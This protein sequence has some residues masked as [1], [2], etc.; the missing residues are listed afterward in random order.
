MDQIR[1]ALVSKADGIVLETAIGHG[2]NVGFYDFTRIKKLFGCDWVESSLNEAA[3]RAPSQDV[4]LFNCDMHKTPFSDGSFDTVVDTFGLECAYDVDRAFAEIKRLTKPGGK[5]LL[6]ERGRGYWLFD[7][8]KLM[9]KCSVNMSARA[10]FY[11]HD[12]AKIVEADHDVK[13]VK[14][15]RKRRGMIYCYELQKL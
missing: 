15:K 11:H 4:T 12:F 5:I 1:R 3:K 14:R 6:L 2:L 10:Q 7:N 13:V 9:L 8:F